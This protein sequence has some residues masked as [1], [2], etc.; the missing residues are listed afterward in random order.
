MLQVDKD[1]FGKFVSQLRKE[2]GM[3]QKELAEKLYLTDKAIS[4]WERGLSYP[5][6]SVLEGLA[7]AL[8]ISLPE[9]LEC[10]LK[11]KTELISISEASELVEK[12][13]SISGEEIS[14]KHMRNKA[15]ILVCCVIT[16][17][18]ISIALNIRNYAAASK[19]KNT[20]WISAN[21][22]AYEVIVDDEGNAAF[23]DPDAALEQLLQDIKNANGGR[24]K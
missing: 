7:E 23:K 8:E 3:T 12:S 10:R 17:L 19:E 5:D 22:K 4:K 24:N 1:T 21:S 18:C 6:I 14:K 11:S 15:V 9:L 2:H 16:M 13:I 20:S